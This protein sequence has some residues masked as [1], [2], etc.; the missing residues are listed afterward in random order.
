MKMIIPDKKLIVTAII[1]SVLVIMA[2][3][4]TFTVPFIF[5]DSINIIENE[6]IRQLWPIWNCFNIPSDTGIVGRPVVNLSLAINYAISGEKVW[7]YHAVN[8]VIH[9]L[10]ALTILVIIRLIILTTEK[11][12]KYLNSVLPFS[13]TCALLWAL[14]PLQTQSVTYVIQRCESLMALFFMLTFYTTIRGWQSSS[15]RRWHLLSVLFFL[16]A[17][18]SKEVAV[19][20]PIMLLLYE[21]VF[22]GN[23]PSRAVKQ[24]PLLYTGLILGL[25]IAIFAVINGNTLISRTTNISFTLLSYWITQCQVIF[26][27]LR[28]AVWPTGLT[29]DYGWPVATIAEVWPSIIGVLILIG[30]S[31]WALLRRNAIGFLGA[32]FF[33]ILAPTS[34]IPLP[35]LIFEH[36][37]YLPL[38]PIIILFI[39]SSFNVYECIK[40]RFS[41]WPNIEASIIAN[42]FWGF[43]ICLGLVFGFLTYQ[44]NY[45]YR[46]AIAILSDTIAKRPD[47]FRGYHG[48][49]LVLSKQGHPDEAL[50]YINRALSLNPENAYANNDKGYI[51]FLMNRPEEAIPFFRKSIQLKP[52]DPKSH[53]NLGAALA[54]T[55]KLEEGILHFSIALKLKPEYSAARGN[56]NIATTALKL[57]SSKK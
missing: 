20:C 19:V 22:R 36:R 5:D 57:K 26:H 32:C 39:G 46:S 9:I 8:L 23:N 17:I 53:N 51:L 55:G 33:L 15:A 28:L 34:L 45:D 35:D 25:I 54:Q 24:S 37:M 43:I 27:Y 16:L 3:S 1:L 2:Y 40:K 38:A 13:F 56:L 50:K 42:S 30:L 11:G 29:L 41:F 52:Y 48:L 31:A 10:T 14:H 6:S 21:W 44:R 12:A 47:N 49:G 18:F 4:N 7:S